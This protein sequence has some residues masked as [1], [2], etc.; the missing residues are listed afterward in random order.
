[1][2]EK[3]HFLC[4]YFTKYFLKGSFFQQITISGRQSF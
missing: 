3:A 4:R 1:M 2:L